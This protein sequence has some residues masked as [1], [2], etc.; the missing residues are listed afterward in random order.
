MKIKWRCNCG[1]EGE[2]EIGCWMRCSN[3][4]CN[5]KNAFQIIELNIPQGE[6]LS[7]EKRLTRLE[8]FIKVS[9]DAKKGLDEVKEQ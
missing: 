6:G 3:K 1:F 9:R 2:S 7:F 8:E 4:D 5:Y